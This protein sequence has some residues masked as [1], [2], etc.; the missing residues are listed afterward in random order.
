MSTANASAAP[1]QKRGAG[2]IKGMQK[3]GRSLQLPVAALPAAGILSRLGQDD[4]FGKAGLGWNKLA[5]IFA[6]AG[7]AL[8]DN[9]ALLFCLGVAI[10]F[11]KKSDGTTAF[12]ALV[13]FLV[14]KNVLTGFV[15]DV[16]GKPQDPG[17]LG[18]IVVGITAAVLWEKYHRTR[19]PDWLGF[20]SGRRFI[21]ILMSFAGVVYGVV[22]GLLWGPIGDGLNSF[23]E[24]LSANGAI[25]SGI[26]G[27][28]NRLLIPVG[29]HMLLN[30]FAWFQFGDFSS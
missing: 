19:L 8:F 23:S 28:V 13:G 17:V 29:M 15:S 6:H 14:Y 25:G 5:E 30:S 22:F 7:G 27:V 4:V 9:L 12:A 16:T 2:L 3:I 1:A 21:P 11:A 24:W 26:F 10:G 18:G 20:F